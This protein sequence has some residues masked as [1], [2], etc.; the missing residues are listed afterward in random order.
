[1]LFDVL[2][3]LFGAAVCYVV[4]VWRLSQPG[5]TL[6]RAIVRPLGGGGPRPGTPR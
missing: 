4:V 6:G 2:T 1:M 5:D 3:F